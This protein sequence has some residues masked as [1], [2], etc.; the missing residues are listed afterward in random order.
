MM[1][2]SM[3]AML[4]IACIIALFVVLGIFLL[5]GKGSFLIAGYNTMS[6]EDKEKYDTVRLT[7]FMGKMMFALSFSMLFW[8][9]SIAYER[10]WLF[11][12]GLILFFGMVVFM[13]I[14]VN[15]GDRF[16]KIK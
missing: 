8:I 3:I 7:K 2:D 6:P 15:T 16:K 14:Y 4:I 12:L 13:I 11:S 10:N 9:L 1:E 5:N